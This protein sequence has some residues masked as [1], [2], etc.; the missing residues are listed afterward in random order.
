MATPNLSGKRILL[1]GAET[2]LGAELAAALG[3]AGASLA[4]VTAA[5]DPATA[6]AVKRL[7][8]KAGAIVAQAIDATNEMAVRVMVRQVSK[9]LGGLD[10]VVFCGPEDG[11]IR[12]LALRFGQKELSRFGGGVLVDAQGRTATQAFAELAAALAA[13]PPTA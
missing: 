3:Q 13:S 7:A 1:I 12:A 11:R 5:N 4:I 6:F 8:R 9:Q 2:S 10:A